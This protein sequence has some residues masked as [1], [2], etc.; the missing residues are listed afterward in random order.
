M[1]TPSQL[2]EWA[3]RPKEPL[4]SAALPP[5][6]L[7]L[8]PLVLGSPQSGQRPGTVAVIHDPVGALPFSHLDDLHDQKVTKIQASP[9]SWLSPFSLPMPFCFTAPPPPGPETPRLWDHENRPPAS[10]P[11]GRLIQ[12]KPLKASF[13]NNFLNQMSFLSHPSLS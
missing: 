7:A 9:L 13:G 8:Q 5:C 12:A 3:P 10:F 6:R 11:A 2:E 4:L 1:E